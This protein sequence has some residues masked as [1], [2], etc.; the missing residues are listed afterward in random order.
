V[1]THCKVFVRYL[2]I[3]D[4]SYQVLSKHNK[5]DLMS[6]CLLPSI[7]ILLESKSNLFFYKVSFL[8]IWNITIAYCIM[9]SSCIPSLS[10]KARVWAYK[11]FLYV[12]YWRQGFNDSYWNLPRYCVVP[13]TKSL[14]YYIFHCHTNSIN[15]YIYVYFNH[16]VSSIIRFIP[17]I[18]NIGMLQDNVYK[19]IKYLY[20]Y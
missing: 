14:L 13:W 4:Y 1:L 11:V 8:I 9:T 19:I 18:N 17:N 2:I 16:S 10:T 6:V 20:N 5:K 3:K 15:K 12:Y 7:K